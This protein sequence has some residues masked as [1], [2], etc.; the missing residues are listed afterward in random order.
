M[1]VAGIDPGLNGAVVVLDTA[2]DHAWRQKLSYNCHGVMTTELFKN[3][4]FSVNKIIVEHVYGRGGWSATATF[5]LGKYY[6]ALIQ[7]IYNL[8][9]EFD[10][11]KP[12]IWTKTLHSY[13]S[14][15]KGAK[16]KSLA[17]YKAMYTH[18]PVGLSKGGRGYHDG[19][20]DAM[21]IATYYFIT[22][23]IPVRVW[24]FND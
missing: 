22:N 1:L 18:D 17:A 14:G 20:I 7:S 16:A 6:G 10:L 21:L 3:V 11:V 4:G 19:T 24:N 12:N 15:V 23:S 2:S 5:G 9:E 13:M 8:G